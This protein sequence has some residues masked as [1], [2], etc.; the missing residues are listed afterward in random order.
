MGLADWE[1]VFGG[2]YGITPERCVSGTHSLKGTGGQGACALVHKSTYNDAP[3]NVEIRTW[4]S[5]GHSSDQDY[6]SYYIGAMSRKQAG[7]NTYAE[8]YLMVQFNTYGEIDSATVTFELVNEGNPDLITGKDVTDDLR[9]LWEYHTENWFWMK[10]RMFESGGRLY[11]NLFITPYIPSPD[12]NNPPEDQLVLLAELYFDQI[13]EYLQ[14]GGACG[15]I[16]GNEQSYPYWG[17]MYIDYT[18]IWY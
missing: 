11:G 9:Q 14:T 17:D 10:A 18:E 7:K 12:V 3:L 5:F 16:F 4:G 13:P 8:I 6:C 1:T 15:I 2:G